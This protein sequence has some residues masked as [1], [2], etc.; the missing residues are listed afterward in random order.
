M[1]VA[2]SFFSIARRFLS[3]VI[4]ISHRSGSQSYVQKSHDRA[5]K[6]FAA[7]LLNDGFFLREALN[8]PPNGLLISLNRL[9]NSLNCLNCLL[10]PLIEFIAQK[11]TNFHSILGRSLGLR[12]VS[13]ASHIFFVPLLT[14]VATEAKRM[15]WN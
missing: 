15:E 13:R 6:Y 12:V 1:W 2:I 11:F 5:K 3:L 8:K 7:P 9:F 10:L 4:H 14:Q